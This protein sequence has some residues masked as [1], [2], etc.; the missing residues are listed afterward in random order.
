MDNKKRIIENVRTS[1]GELARD[2]ASC[3]GERGGFVSDSKVYDP[4][5]IGKLPKEA[6]AASAGCGN[7]NAIGELRQGETVVDFG[8]GGG[9]D[10]FLA[11]Y[12]DGISYALAKSV[13]KD[14]RMVE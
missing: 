1:Y 5:H 6:L 14:E 12:G 9:I 2:V 3:C 4:K 13:E 11:R 7:P 8:S 10:C